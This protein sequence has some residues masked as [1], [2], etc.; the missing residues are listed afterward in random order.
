MKF[1]HVDLTREIDMRYAMQ[2]AEVPV[3]VPDHDDF[4]KA[5]EEVVTLFERRYAELYGEGTGFRE[6]G[7]QSITYRVRGTGV[8]GTAPQLPPLAAAPSSDSSSAIKEAR[9]VSLDLEIGFVDTPVY[10]YSK[11]GAGHVIHGPAI[12]EVPT[13]TVVIPHKRTGTVDSLG[14]LIITN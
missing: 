1:D 8:L 11:L 12:I 10:D 6:A 2:L 5:L 14:N 9:P 4:P 7:I 13:T 3:E